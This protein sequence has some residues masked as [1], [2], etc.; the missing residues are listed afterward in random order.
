MELMASLSSALLVLSMQQ[1]STHAYWIPSARA[2]SHVFR[3]LEYPNVYRAGCER[4]AA[5]AIISW[6]ESSWSRSQVWDKM[7]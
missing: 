5:A 1:V 6:Y 3:I 7:A 4:P 2:I